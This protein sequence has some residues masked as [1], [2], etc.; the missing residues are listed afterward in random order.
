MKGL[1]GHGP[2]GMARPGSMSCP[3][4]A[5]MV[6]RPHKRPGGFL[7]RSGTEPLKQARQE[8]AI[9]KHKL[10]LMHK[11]STPQPSFQRPGPSQF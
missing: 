9:I 1:A 5:L 8:C 4:P 11:V 3:Q 7:S 2:S 10:H 6:T